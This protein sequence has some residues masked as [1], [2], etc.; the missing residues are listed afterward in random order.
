MLADRQMRPSMLWPQIKQVAITYLTQRYLRWGLA[1]FGLIMLPNLF[2][3]GTP[4]P[5][6]AA[7]PMLFL[8]GMPMFMLLPPL[9]GQVKMQFAHSRA[10]LI[11]QFLPAHLATL[12]G[13]LVTVLLLYPLG[14]AGLA[15]LEPLGLMALAVAIGAPALWGAQL[16][17]FG[18][19]FVSMGVF[20]SLLTEWG[21]R[22]WIVNAAEHRPT[23][24][25]IVLAGGVLV[26]SWL[27]RLCHLHEEMDDYQN[28]YQQWLAR[29]SGS[30]AVEQ[31]RIV[32]GYI[33]RHKFL[34]WV[35]DWWHER[36]GGYH[37]GRKFQISR[38]LRYGFAANPV[39]VQG[40]FILA[41]FLALGVFM[42][43]FS[44]AWTTDGGF[45]RLWFFVM[46]A[47]LLPGHMAGE[48]MAQRRPRIAFE[49]LLPLSR[50]QLVDALFA[51]SVR[52]SL[53]L[54]LMMNAGLAVVVTLAIEAVPL[55][56]AAMFIL[57]SGS[58]MF[59]SMSI[60]L[61]ISIWPSMA[62]RWIIV[63]SS[64]MVLLP[65]IIIWWNVRDEIGDAPFLIVA[66]VLMAM[67]ATL[68]RSARRAWLTLE[69]G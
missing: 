28:V 63:W 45:G 15:G 49:M 55:G 36:L 65:P 48:M 59:V 33:R 53:V 14:L 4:K 17:R 47:A 8:I 50:G 22:W 16:N 34:S 37:G 24:A 30:E 10:R 7:Q 12:C 39:E 13:I 43:K 3:V 25:L 38:L 23:H 41:V 9:V 35:G 31:R 58:A 54:W 57:L 67:G 27:W 40:L 20:Y 56:T 64:W 42:S 46:F 69:L 2:V 6:A 18:P 51:A 44:Y 62:K 32:A 19:M 61:R 60:G 26:V 11:P 29:R 68:L 1:L 5:E 66:G 21:L 52:N